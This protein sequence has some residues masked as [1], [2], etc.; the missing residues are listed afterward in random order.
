MRSPVFNARNRTTSQRKEI[1]GNPTGYDRMDNRDA[2]WAVPTPAPPQHPAAASD[3]PADSLNPLAPDTAVGKYR[4]VAVLGQGAFGITYQA[5]DT[6][7]DRAVAIKEYMPMYFAARQN[8]HSVLPRS[9][10]VAEDFRWGRERFLA[11]ARTLARLEKAVGVVNV[12]DFLEVNGTAYMVMELVAGDTLE[13]RLR[14]ERQLPQ[15][16]IERLLYPLLDGLERVHEAGFLHRDIKPANILID[17]T[18]HPT[19]IDFGAAR[20]ALHGRTQ[21]MTAIYTPGYAAFEQFTSA[22]QGPWTDIYA[23]GATLYHCATGRLPPAASDRMIDDAL[24]PATQ[25]AKG[26]LAPGLL[27]AIDWALKLKAADRPQTIGQWRRILSGES[28]GPTVRLATPIAANGPKKRTR[29]WWLAGLAAAVAAAGAAGGGVHLWQQRQDALVRQEV[30]RRAVEDAERKAAAE[31]AEADLAARRQAEEAA[32]RREAEARARTDAE[33]KQHGADAAARPQ[34][35]TSASPP[36]DAKPAGND[37]QARQVQAHIERGADHARKGAYDR[38]IDEYTQAIR[39]QPASALAFYNR[40]DAYSSMGDYDRAI[41]DFTQALTL[42]SDFAMAFNGRGVA[43]DGKG[44]TDQAIRDYD[45]AIKLKPDYAEAFYN[46]GRA[47]KRKGQDDRATQDYDQAIRLKPDFAVAFNNRGNIYRGKGQFDRAI[48][49]YDEAIKRDPAF[50]IAFKNRGDVYASKGQLDRAIQDYSQAIRIAPDFA[51][52]F[53]DRGDVYYRRGE[54]ERSIQDF[55]AATKLDPKNAVTWHGLCSARALVGQ[56]EAALTDCT[57]SLKLRPNDPNALDSRGFALLKLGRLDDAIVDYTSALTVD[58][59]RAV[60]LYS[61]GIAR[62]R[63]GDTAAARTDMTAAAA[64]DR[65][66]A[67]KMRKYGVQ[68]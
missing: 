25:A 38:A 65:N 51:V 7:L 8:D 48:Q 1:I 5:H 45:Q 30:E 35:A 34:T 37:A 42:Q 23:L 10:R 3:T 54:Y 11:E 31:K 4:I 46:R 18:G 41:Q 40:G 17:R 62:L 39:L 15:P 14:R 64:I 57:E 12:Y 67:A 52:A 13:M 68:P 49:D 63:K 33:S 53:K 55:S 66:I 28:S 47:Y 24:V 21:A 9:T 60:S 56:L 43:Y 29:G 50:V 32:A 58:A 27:A 20:V 59:R 44:D 19:L 61:R 6:Q 2:A 22:H 36:S 16:V 26:Q